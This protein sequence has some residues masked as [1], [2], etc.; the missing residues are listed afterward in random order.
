MKAIFACPIELS[1]VRLQVKVS[2]LTIRLTLMN[3]FLRVILALNTI[4][5]SFETWLDNETGPM[6]VFRMIHRTE[7]IPGMFRGLEAMLWRWVCSYN[8]YLNC[9]RLKTK[10][11][12]FFHIHSDAIPYGIF[13]FVY[14]YLVEKIRIQ[15]ARKTFHYKEETV[16]PMRTAL[17]GACAGMLS[18]LPGIPFDVIKTRMMTATSPDQYKSVYHCFRVITKV[19]D[20]HESAGT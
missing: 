7:G 4:M 18:W 8:K 19:S 20:S 6:M 1:K 10:R 13:M 14:E 11:L 5:Y 12:C 16:E 17:A 2:K 9:H 15:S 3:Y